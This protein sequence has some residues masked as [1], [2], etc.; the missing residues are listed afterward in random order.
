SKLAITNVYDDVKL[1]GD[2]PNNGETDDN[3][4]LISGTGAEAGDTITVYNG[5]TVIGSTT[6]KSDGTWELE[7]STPLPDGTYRL[8]AKETDK[9]GN[10]A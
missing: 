9:V 6:V 10:E 4:P 1:A 7:P 2:V 8:T 5:N 3:R